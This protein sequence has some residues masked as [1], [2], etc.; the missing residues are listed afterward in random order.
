MK[1]LMLAVIAFSFLITSCGSAKQTGSG[2]TDNHPTAGHDTSM[3]ASDSGSDNSMTAIMM[4][5]MDQMKNMKSTNDPDQDF[6]LMMKHHHEGATKMAQLE[7]SKGNN[8]D[9]KSMAQLMINDQSKEIEE[10]NHFISNHALGNNSTNDK[11]YHECMHMMKDNPMNMDDK[12]SDTD[13][14]FANMMISHHEQGIRM[15]EIYLKHGKHE[16]LKTMATNMMSKQNGEI[17]KLK[18]W[19]TN[20]N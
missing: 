1:N 7:L 4:K 13:H 18:E 15:S 12:T 5:H 17:T 16:E 8:K 3:S 2:N 9:L 14:Q 11:F 19:Q 6:A 10:L 20:H